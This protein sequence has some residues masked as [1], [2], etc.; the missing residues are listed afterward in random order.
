MQEY[1]SYEDQVSLEEEGTVLRNGVK[2]LWIYKK[3]EYKCFFIDEKRVLMYSDGEIREYL[4]SQFKNRDVLEEFFFN[5]FNF[6]KE[7]KNSLVNGVLEIYG[8]SDDP[9]YRIRVFFKKDY[10]PYKVQIESQ[11][12]KI[13][14][15]FR[16]FKERKY[17]FSIKDCKP[18][19]KN[20]GIP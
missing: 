3:P 20:D 9:F 10:M 8:R 16:S 5:P 15:L 4:K 2:W 14:F 18:E 17:I 12:E 7:R 13:E 11:D 1:F 19:N 6:L